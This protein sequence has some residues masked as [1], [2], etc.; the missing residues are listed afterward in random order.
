ML[1]VLI[2]GR[3]AHSTDQRNVLDDA[4]SSQI[5][6]S[7]AVK[8]AKSLR[9]RVKKARRKSREYAEK[10]LEPSDEVSA[11]FSPV[12]LSKDNLHVLVRE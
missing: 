4:F 6:E 11:H 7:I 12:N 2:S 10:L 8:P 3:W 5:N 1:K 9:K